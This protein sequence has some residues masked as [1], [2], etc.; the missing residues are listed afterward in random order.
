[1]GSKASRSTPLGKRWSLRM[2]LL[3]LEDDLA[4]PAAGSEAFIGVGGGAQRVGAIDRY[5]DR[6]QGEGVERSG[7]RPARQDGFL[8]W[9]AGAA[10]RVTRASTFGVSPS[11]GPRHQTHLTFC[12]TG[13]SSNPACAAFGFGKPYPRSTW[14]S[15]A[16][17]PGLSNPLT[18]Y[19][20]TGVCNADCT[21]LWRNAPSAVVHRACLGPSQAPHL[22]AA[23]PH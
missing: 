22:P 14:S 7:A 4:E 11:H 2:S 5:G 16:P 9:G 6:P 23:P 21:A 10:G 8:A 1:M 3:H 19:Q 17:P 18:E 13:R 15:R 20:P 12:P